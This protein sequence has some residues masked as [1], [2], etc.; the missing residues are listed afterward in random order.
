MFNISGGIACVSSFLVACYYFGNMP[1]VKRNF[2]IV[3]FA[4]IFISLLPTIIEVWRARS[5]RPAT[6]NNAH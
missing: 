5:Q 6:P 4:I 2:H 3:I 1:I